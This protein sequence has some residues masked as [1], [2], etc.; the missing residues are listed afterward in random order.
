MVEGIGSRNSRPKKDP[1]SG[2][3]SG[4]G[5]TMRHRCARPLLAAGQR[6]RSPQ[7]ARRGC[8]TRCGGRVVWRACGAWA[9]SVLTG[10]KMGLKFSEHIRNLDALH[11]CFRG[12]SLFMPPS[13]SDDDAC[14][15]PST[16]LALP[17][18]YQPGLS[19]CPRQRHG[20]AARLLIFKVTGPRSEAV[21]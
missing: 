1:C 8:C 3:I 5:P 9:S 19:Q 7:E 16:L 14:K 15:P 20:L 2:L 4:R 12:Q 6:G 13:L 10:A 18:V 11:H 17:F 21:E